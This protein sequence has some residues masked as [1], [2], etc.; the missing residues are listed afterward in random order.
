LPTDS[1]PPLG[2]GARGGGCL[3]IDA[4]G[5]LLSLALSSQVEERGF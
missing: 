3:D 1:H 5:Y 2:G 4:A